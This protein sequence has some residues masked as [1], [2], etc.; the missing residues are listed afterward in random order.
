M[1]PRRGRGRAG[2]RRVRTAARGRSR[3]ADGVPGRDGVLRLDRAHWHRVRE[4]RPGVR[5]G[6]ERHHQGLPTGSATAPQASSPTCG[7]TSSTSGT[8][9]CS[10]WRSTPTSRPIHGSTSSHLRRPARRHRAALRLRHGHIRPVPVATGLHGRRLRRHRP[11]VPLAGRGN[12]MSGPEQ[13]LIRDWCQQYPSHSIGGLAASAPGQND[14][15]RRRQAPAPPP[16]RAARR[17]RWPSS[18]PSG[19]G[20][21]PWGRRSTCCL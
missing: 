8:A 3:A 13:V 16:A 6:E 19:S 4:R 14:E 9:G 21:G 7:A 12:V 5:L 18:S 1:G 11:A 2:P 17:P 15:N 10:G 20:W